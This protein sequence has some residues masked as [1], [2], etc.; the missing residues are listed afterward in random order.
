[1][2]RERCVLRLNQGINNS[3]LDVATVSLLRCSNRSNGALSS[4][5]RFGQL[6][7]EA[8]DSRVTLAL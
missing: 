2:R 5:I 4:G 6:S 8:L 7:A 3:F 1:M